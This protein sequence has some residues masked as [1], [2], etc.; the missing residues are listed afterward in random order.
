MLRF[1]SAG[2]TNKTESFLASILSSDPSSIL[3]GAAQRGVAALQKATPKDSG[4]TADQWTYEIQR[5]GGQ[6]T[7][8][9]VN[10]N[11]VNGFNVAVGLQYGH[12]TGTGGWIAGQD[13][14]NGALKPIF[15]QIANDVWK[16]VQK[17]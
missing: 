14:I 17:A 2:S 16:G 10:T 6:T 13:Y 5:K 12:G 8:W 4:A 1:T 7:L 3:E 15:D 9:F 11:S